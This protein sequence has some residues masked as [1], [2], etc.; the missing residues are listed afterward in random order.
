MPIWKN[1]HNPNNL[2]QIGAILGQKFPATFGPNRQASFIA[3]TSGNSR[4]IHNPSAFLPIWLV[5]WVFF[6]W[7]LL[8]RVV[9][10]ETSPS[11]DIVQPSCWWA[12]SAPFTCNFNSHLEISRVL[13]LCDIQFWLWSGLLLA[14]QNG[15]ELQQNLHCRFWQKC[16]QDE[17]G[18]R[19]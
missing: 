19:L 8:C 5:K 1:F 17:Q 4:H 15:P 14:T 3:H 11:S 6:F 7:C 13:R 9:N 10:N 16:L 2:V 12:T 18:E